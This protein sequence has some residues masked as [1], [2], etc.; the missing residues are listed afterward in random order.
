[1]ELTL[2]AVSVL[3]RDIYIGE[4]QA[5]VV[6][7]DSVRRAG[8]VQE[9]DRVVARGRGQVRGQV[10]G[11]NG[12]PLAGARVAILSGASEARTDEHGVFVLPSLPHGT[13]T[14]EARALGYL[15]AQEII[16]IV[17]FRES[18]AEFNLIDL[19]AVFLDTVRVAAARQLEAAARASFE[20]RKRGGVGYFLEES[21]I[22]TMRAFSFKDLVRSIPGVRFVRGNSIEDSWREHVEF[23]FGG[24][25]EPCLP[26][27][28]LDGTLLLSGKT[29]LD[30][31]INPDVVRRVEVYHRGANI[32]A[33]FASAVHCGVLAVW[34]GIRPPKPRGSDA[35]PTL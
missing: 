24:R 5:E 32:P 7:G 31:I 15:P 3:R 8:A 2:A 29:D 11:T 13:H 12:R 17:S 18:S 14:I 16:D 10:R 1:V 33:E 21:Q 28:Y 25:S 34:T 6:T 4:A 23:T 19:Q 35:R 20:R 22:D 26:A 9:G 30:V 27:I